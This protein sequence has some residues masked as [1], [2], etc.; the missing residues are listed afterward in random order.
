[1]E[2]ASRKPSWPAFMCEREN[3]PD[4]SMDGPDL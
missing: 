2:L 1:L 3:R 4:I